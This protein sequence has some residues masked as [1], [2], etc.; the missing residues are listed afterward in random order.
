MQEKSVDK[1]LCGDILG[2][3]ELKSSGY[4]LEVKNIRRLLAHI[5]DEYDPSEGPFRETLQLIADQ[6]IG[7]GEKESVH[8]NLPVTSETQSQE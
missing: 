5:L 1:F 7:K 3:R 4:P 2:L 8:R 6:F